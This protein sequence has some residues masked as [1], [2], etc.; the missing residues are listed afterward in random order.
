MPPWDARG[1][2]DIH[3]ALTDVLVEMFEV[4]PGDVTE[5][6]DLYDDLDIDSI[7]AVDL[8]V[9]LE[10]VTSEQIEPAR[11][12]GVR[13]VGDVTDLLADLLAS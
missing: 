3:S 12:K 9:R 11:V 5:E 6:A 13:T 2:E 7:D 10:E 4:E 8:I 1:R